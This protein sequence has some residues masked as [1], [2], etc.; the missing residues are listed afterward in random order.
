MENKNLTVYVY[1]PVLRDHDA[2]SNDA[3]QMVHWLQSAG[4]KTSLIAREIHKKESNLFVSLSDL[5]K[6]ALLKKDATLILHFC[7]YDR[8][9]RHLLQVLSGPVLLRYHDITPSFLFGIKQW[10][11][12]LFSIFGQIQIRRL[13]QNSRIQKIIT[14][15]KWTF[16]SLSTSSKFFNV[17]LPPLTLQEDTVCVGPTNHVPK[18]VLLVGRW[19]HHKGYGDLT[20][21][22][23][24]L[25]IL[26]QRESPS[27]RFCFTIGGVVQRPFEAFANQIFNQLKAFKDVAEINC[28]FGLSD[29][30]LTSLYQTHKVF[31]SL[32]K[33]EGFGVPLI[34]AQRKGMPVIA[35]NAAAIPETLGQSGLLIDQHDSDAFKKVAKGIMQL[36]EDQDY[37]EKVSSKGNENIQR[38]DPEFLKKIFFDQVLR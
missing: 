1:I 20:A 25:R 6:V 8:T 10:R 26:S 16:N 14:A 29:L 32:S 12:I 27:T 4:Y 11:S 9:L 18:S 21:V 5:K 22:L 28:Y 19:S 23:G 7:G 3:L 34:E 36:L 2:A 24:E 30:A 37:Y 33:H 13:M 38:F 17:V 31:L 15:S 35:L